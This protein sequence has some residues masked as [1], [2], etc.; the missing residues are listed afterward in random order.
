MNQ[1]DENILQGKVLVYECGGAIIIG[2][3]G[4]SYRVVDEYLDKIIKE[5]E[6]ECQA[7][8]KNR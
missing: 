4:K 7:L 5:K 2:K 1:F 8:E 3:N 6:L